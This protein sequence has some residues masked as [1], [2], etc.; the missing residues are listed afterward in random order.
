LIV[1]GIF[2]GLSGYKATQMTV[3]L[4]TTTLVPDGSYLTQYYDDVEAFFPNGEGSGAT[5]VVVFKD[6]D[7]SLPE[8]QVEIFRVLEEYE[9]EGVLTTDVNWLSN[10]YEWAETTYNSSL[11]TVE[12]PV[13]PSS[14]RA[15]TVLRV[16]RQEDFYPWLHEF[17]QAAIIGEVHTPL[18]AFNRES[19]AC[20]DADEFDCSIVA[21]I[22]TCTNVMYNEAEPALA[23]M[24]M[25]MD[26]SE[27][28]SLD[29]VAVTEIYVYLVLNLAMQ[30][31]LAQN[32]LLALVAVTFV[33]CA[34]L[35]SL[36][37][38][39]V[40]TLNI[41]MIDL[42]IMGLMVWAGIP[43][44]PVSLVCLVMS[45]GLSFDYTAH[46]SHCFTTQFGGT[47]GKRVG[48]TL[49]K[50]G[51]D[52]F[53][54]AFS[55]W[56]GLLF[57]TAAGSEI[58][59]TFFWVFFFVV[60]CAVAH[61]F[62]FT[63]AVLSLFG[64]QALHHFKA[65]DA[66]GSA[67]KGGGDGVSPVAE[68]RTMDSGHGNTNGVNEAVATFSTRAY[69]KRSWSH[70]ASAPSEDKPVM[71]CHV[72]MYTLLASLVVLGMSGT[73][74]AP[75]LDLSDAVLETDIMEWN[76]AH[77][78]AAEETSLEVMF[79]MPPLEV[80]TERT[81]YFCSGFEWPDD[82]Q[83]HAV[84]FDSYIDQPEVVHHIIIFNCLSQWKPE[85]QVCGDMPKDCISFVYLWAVGSEPMVAPEEAGMRV[86][87]G[88]DA[89]H[90]VVQIHYDNPLH[91]PGIVDRS[92]VRVKLTSDLRPNDAGVLSVGLTFSAV[93][94]PPQQAAYH[95]QGSCPY[96]NAGQQMADFFGD[97]QDTVNL[98]AY[99]LHQHVLGRKIWSVLHKPAPDGFT[100]IKDLGHNMVYDFEVQK[101]IHTNRIFWTGIHP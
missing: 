45:I 87:R 89:L 92:G 51:L 82:S 31:E 93:N 14:N 42:E 6:A 26:I 3:G 25:V 48:M 68:L 13:P 47:N 85:P 101:V 86:G 12:V 71:A 57:L 34:L 60:V 98:Y 97:E 1:F 94:I 17:L 61:G 43:L 63:P 67:T 8:T 41:F 66:D 18:F 50:V 38:A 90:G 76:V 22:V 91:K 79:T 28:S 56:L 49:A 72:I 84:E 20:I 58:F 64:T 46:I 52:V 77:S 16:P 75:I 9:R 54:G 59:R 35:R 7:Y 95:L 74:A 39:C 10:F 36:S 88:T 30:G 70:L 29:V 4:D 32:L 19:E 73:F 23:D 100:E 65:G 44:D 21:T 5:V 78:L 80:P 24:Q 33:G 53:R 11:V 2:A 83:Y 99:G 96:G 69:L 40:V 15:P 55:T 62:V 81:S 37:V 27:R